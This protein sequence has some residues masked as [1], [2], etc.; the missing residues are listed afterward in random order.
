MQHLIDAAEV[1]MQTPVLHSLRAVIDLL[2]SGRAPAEV[3]VFLA[4]GN[5]TALNKP[6]PGD[7][8]PIAVG[9]SIRR[10]TG[11]CLCVALKE[12]AA[13]LIEPFQFGIT[14]PMVLKKL[15]MV[16]ELA[17]ISI[18]SMMSLEF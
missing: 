1:H 18:G 9:E 11:K 17:W 10:L 16:C 13:S 4:S 5:L 6:A 8:Q 15:F 12:R 7:I 2:V 14:C 3:A